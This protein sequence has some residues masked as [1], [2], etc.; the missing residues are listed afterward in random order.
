MFWDKRHPIFKGMQLV[1][2]QGNCDAVGIQ[3]EYNS[4]VAVLVRGYFSC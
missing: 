3:Q 4:Y 1:Y 2:H